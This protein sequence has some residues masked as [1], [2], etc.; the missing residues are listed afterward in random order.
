MNIFSK[1]FG[2]KD[3]EE[4]RET[5]VEEV[6][7]NEDEQNEALPDLKNLPEAL[8]YVVNKW[9]SDYLRNRSLL[10]I[11]ND[12]QVLKDMPAAK[13]II[14]NMQVNGYIEKI[15]CIKNWEFE[16]KSISTKYSNEF[17]AKEDIVFYL[18]QCFGYG[19]QI[20]SN[21]P[22]LAEPEEFK[23]TLE[24]PKPTTNIVPP[25][26]NNTPSAPN[27][28]P[29]APN[30][31]QHTPLGPYDPK[32]DLDSYSYPTIDLLDDYN[33]N[34]GIVSLKSVLSSP[35]FQNTPMQLPC[36]IGKKD[37]G[38]ILMFDLIDTPHIMVS[39]SSGMGVS[40]FFN[41]L[42]S[43]LLFKKH[44]AEVK[45][46]MVDPKKIEFS[47]YKPIEYN[48]LATLPEKE[49]IITDMSNVTDTFVSLT[50]EID[51]RQELLSNA[52]VRSIK[53]YN[54]KFC[55]RKLNPS[56]GHHYLPYIILLIDEYD[57]LARMCGRLMESSLEKITKMGRA[58]GIC[59][60]LS[61]LRPVGTVISSAIKANMFG[62]ISFRVPSSNDSRNI[63]GQSGAEKLQRPGDM[64]YSDGINYIKGRCAYME[65]SEVERIND[66]IKNQ[67]GYLSAYELPN[68]NEE[69]SL[70]P[71]QQN[72]VDMSHLDPLFEDAARLVVINQSGSPSLIQRKFAIGYN[73]CGRMLD[74]MEKAGIVGPFMGSKPREVLINDEY[75]LNLIL[76]KYR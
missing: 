48:Y 36:A 69:E 64:I 26:P 19:L 18:V 62:R 45:F 38:D 16:S 29:S 43:S 60:I 51:S 21:I 59:V 2:S 41:T 55:E 71:Y 34:D 68:P 73:R 76:N 24:T 63:L 61:I 5:I 58:T 28:T 49:P 9:G 72:D 30:N 52:S 11:L 75:S 35:E 70:W 13:H 54:R 56:D 1:W 23:T 67:Q 39:G 50:K 46:V 6:H 20:C 7:F 66:F 3:E 33:P 40:I 10:N 42:I 27:N 37:N 47:L 8:R 65:L 74:Q 12:F 57:E 17:G 44:P 22:K 4:Q 14:Q 32:R 25:A 53:D 15:S 31:P